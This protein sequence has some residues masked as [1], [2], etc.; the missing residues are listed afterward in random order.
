MEAR[1]RSRNTR[2]EPEDNNPRRTNEPRMSVASSSTTGRSKH[3]EPFINPSNLRW[4][5]VISLTLTTI[6]GTYRSF[7]IYSKD[8]PEKAIHQLTR[9]PIS[10]LFSV[11][12]IDQ[13]STTNTLPYFA[14]KSNFFNQKFVKLGWAWTSLAI[15]FHS[16]AIASCYFGAPKDQADLSNSS[17]HPSEESKRSA[18]LESSIARDPSHPSH[19]VPRILSLHLIATILWTLLTQ[20][21]FGSSLIE[22]VL[23]LSGA[24]CVPSLKP[25]NTPGSIPEHTT[26][27]LENV[28]CQTRWG[29]RLPNLDTF[30]LSTHRP[31][32]SGGID[33]SGHTFLLSFS[34]LVIVSALQPSLHHLILKSREKIPTSYRIAIYVNVGIL[35][36]WWWML[37]M[38]SLY[39]HGPIEKFSGL[40]LGTGSWFLVEL[41]V[42]RLLA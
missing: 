18:E 10:S 11:H 23:I 21:F 16:I 40:I 20:W 25:Q 34:I 19:H 3:L 39:F 26:N 15:W 9:I 8:N 24:K 33:V 6:L 7:S 30:T 37:L 29:K 42:D 32:W 31:Y 41:I 17:S 4:I 13:K 5:I 27:Q 36:L 14:N 12:S 35:I 38:T 22:R 2:Q 1:L 28:Y